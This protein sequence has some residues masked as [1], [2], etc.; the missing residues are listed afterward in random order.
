MLAMQCFIFLLH[1]L[2]L[3][4]PLKI[5]RCETVFEIL[6]ALGHHVASRVAILLCAEFFLQLFRAL[7]YLVIGHEASGLRRRRLCTRVLLGPREEA[8]AFV[9]GVVHQGALPVA[10]LALTLHLLGSVLHAALGGASLSRA[11]CDLSGCSG[12]EGPLRHLDGLLPR[13]LHLYFLLFLPLVLHVL[14][15]G[16]GVVLSCLL[17]LRLLR[18]PQTGNTLVL[19]CQLWPLPVQEA[20]VVQDL[21]G[22]LLGLGRRQGLLQRVA[23][24]CSWGLRLDLPN[25][26]LRNPLLTGLAEARKH[27]LD[28]LQLLGLLLRVGDRAKVLEHLPIDLPDDLR[29]PATSSDGLRQLAGTPVVTQV[30]LKRHTR[31]SRCL[32]GVHLFAGTLL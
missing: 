8:P 28:L 29:V 4:C 2:R 16:D 30:V 32:S 25:L 1:L 26:C 18:R 23:G 31:I 17:P 7:G 19:I 6:V 12:G 11:G 10:E 13:L 20:A 21:P 14:V 27:R 3:D 22:L 24:L 9:P 15:Q 5:V